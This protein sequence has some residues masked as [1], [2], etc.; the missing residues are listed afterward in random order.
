MVG[1]QI[2]SCPNCIQTQSAQYQ[3]EKYGKGMRVMNVD[4]AGKSAV[5]TVCGKSR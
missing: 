1:V 4:R 2:Q 5:C 3:D